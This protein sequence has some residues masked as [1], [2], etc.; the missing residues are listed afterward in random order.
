MAFLRKSEALLQLLA[1][2]AGGSESGGVCVLF[3][4]HDEFVRLVGL[5]SLVLESLLDL[6]ESLVL[7]FTLHFA[8]LVL[9]LLYDLLSYFLSLGHHAWHVGDHHRDDNLEADHDMLEEDAEQDDI[10]AVP[11]V[12]VAFHEV[13]HHGRLLFDCE[14]VQVL[15]HAHLLLG[16]AAEQ[17]NEHVDRD[18][19]EGYEVHDACPVSNAARSLREVAS[20]VARNVLHLDHNL[21]QVRQEGE[22]GRKGESR[23]EEGNEAQLDH[24][25]VIEVDQGRSRRLHLQLARDHLVHLD[26]G[27]TQL[28][29]LHLSHGKRLR[30]EL[31]H[32]LDLLANGDA[33]REELVGV[34]EDLLEEHDD[35]QVSR[36]RRVVLVVHDHHEV[37]NVRV[38]ELEHVRLVRD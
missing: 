20:A 11:E 7:A 17:Q 27:L 4:D 29:L 18:G 24:A 8:H 6:L 23:G 16:E 26:V 9:R 15:R 2:L 13:L 10:G 14:P 30:E 34:D 12:G 19:H 31:V 25:L 21:E 5:F 38:D 32:L 28:V 22:Q 1:L 35:G 37:R 33:L 36:Q 3:A